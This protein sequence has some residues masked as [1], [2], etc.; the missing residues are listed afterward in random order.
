LKSDLYIHEPRR[1]SIYTAPEKSWYQ[2]EKLRPHSGQD[3]FFVADIGASESNGIA[4][5]V[6]DGVGG[7]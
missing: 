4:F 3:A 6:A 5:G 1:L 2:R 7:V